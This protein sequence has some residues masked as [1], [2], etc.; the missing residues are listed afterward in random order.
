M[1][2]DTYTIHY[3]HGDMSILAN[4]GY[5]SRDTLIYHYISIFK[6]ILY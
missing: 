4:L 2:W 3:G 1:T 5:Y 6:Y